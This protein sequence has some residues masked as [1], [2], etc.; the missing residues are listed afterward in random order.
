VRE[1]RYTEK[2]REGER[3]EEVPNL[4]PAAKAFCPRK[5]RRICEIAEM[6]HFPQPVRSKGGSER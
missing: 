5:K 2:G 1:R 6:S 3:E 4:S